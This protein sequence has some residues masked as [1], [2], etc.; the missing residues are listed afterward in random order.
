MVEKTF[1]AGRFEFKITSTGDLYR[2]LIFTKRWKLIDGWVNDNGYKRVSI[3][4]RMIYI[5]QLVARHLIPN[6]MGFTD[7]NHID[8][9]KLNNSIDNLEWCNRSHNIQHAYDMGLRPDKKKLS[10]VQINQ[11]KELRLNGTKLKTL[12]TMFA[13]GMATASRFSRPR[14]H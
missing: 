6:P 8:G 1:K 3:Q 2:W 5:H 4:K 7:I 11:M 12:C 14:R 10:I 9:V 13:I